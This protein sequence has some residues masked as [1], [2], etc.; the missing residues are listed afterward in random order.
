MNSPSGLTPPGVVGCRESVR[1]S[2]CCR[3]SSH[4]TG[5]AVRSCGIVPPAASFG[6]PEYAG[7]SWIA[8]ALTSDGDRIAA[9]ASAGTGYS[10]STENVTLVRFGCGS[11]ASTLPTSTPR[12]RTSSPLYRPLALAK[13]AT[14]VL[15]DTRS[16]HGVATTVV[17]T[18]RITARVAA[19]AIRHLCWGPGREEDQIDIVTDLRL[20][21]RAPAVR[22]SVAAVPLGPA[23]VPAAPAE[24]R[25]AAAQAG[26]RG[27]DSNP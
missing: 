27:T 23:P 1:F 17:A 9:R 4:S 22:P 7:T 21:A 16:H 3:K 12:M 6:P 10:L 14:K 18:A 25:R 24:G 8:R 19:S 2:S 15:L 11:I 5:T 20:A 26:A 13:Y